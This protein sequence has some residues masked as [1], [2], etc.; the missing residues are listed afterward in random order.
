MKLHGALPLLALLSFFPTDV[1]GQFD[2][3]TNETMTHSMENSVVG[4]LYSD[5]VAPTDTTTTLV[6]TDTTVS[7]AEESSMAPTEEASMTA[8]TTSSM[9]A[10]DL[11]SNTMETDVPKQTEAPT[12]EE[13]L[14]LSE[15]EENTTCS[16]ER[17]C[18]MCIGDCDNDSDCQG[19]LE[20]FRR[21]GDSVSAVPGC[22]GT[23][24]PGHDYC[25]EP[26]DNHLRLR[27]TQCSTENP[28]Q[29]CEGDCDNDFQCSGDL[30]CYQIE[31]GAFEAVPG[32]IGVGSGLDFCYNW[33]G[34]IADNDCPPLPCNEEPC[35]QH[36]CRDSECVILATCGQNLCGEGEYCCN[37]SCGVC[38]PMGGGC[39][40][41]VCDAQCGPAVCQAGDVCCNESCGICT[42]PRDTCTE[43]FCEG[44][45]MR[46]RVLNEHLQSAKAGSG[47]QEP[48]SFLRKL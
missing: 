18:G 27:S 14:A 36:V 47:M 16:P 28:C 24:V 23:G 26:E 2:S 43:Q 35:N 15:A 3:L 48:P 46:R 5:T 19:S 9:I 11:A 31:T 4:T 45:D 10:T 8:T 17:P 30:L 34:C 1:L 39:T 42:L 29:L 6:E 37:E 44:D 13:L 32:C 38:A 7:T 12:L 25:Y 21:S 22:A 33:N 41:Q 20:C 40:Q